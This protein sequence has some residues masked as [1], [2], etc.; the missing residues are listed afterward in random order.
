[1]LVTRPVSLAFDR[2]A[3][4]DAVPRVGLELLDAERD[5]VRL[6][7]EL[8]DLDLDGL[9]DVDDLGRVVDAP[10]R[11]VGDVQQAVDAAEV[12]EGAV[13]G[14]VLDD[15]VD[16]LALFEV[17]DELG[18]LLGPALLEHGAARH[19]DVAAPAVHLEDLERLRHAHERRHVAHRPHVDLASAAG[20]H[21]AVEVDG[22]A[23]L[24]LV[25][26]HAG[27]ALVRLERLLEL[28]Q[29]PRGAPCRATGPPRRA[30]SRCAR[31]RPRPRRRP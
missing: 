21:G 18:A 20:S 24:D 17:R 1:M 11:H 31:D 15:A 13:L 29:P 5:A 27:D 28:T 30:R 9:A 16:D 22:E 2:I 19:D 8:E 7:V 14:D 26:D 6:V 23:A 10:P 4:G 12:D 3:G 25:E